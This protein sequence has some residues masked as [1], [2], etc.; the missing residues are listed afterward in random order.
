M[1]REFARVKPD[2]GSPAHA[3]PAIRTTRPVPWTKPRVWRETV[4]VQV[5]LERVKGAGAPAFDS[6]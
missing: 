1:P 3:L 4:R 2:L 5:H 6:A